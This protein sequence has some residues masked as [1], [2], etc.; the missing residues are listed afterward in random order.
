VLDVAPEG[1]MHQFWDAISVVSGIAIP[2]VVGIIVLSL[3]FR[4]TRRLAGEGTDLERFSI[5]GVLGN[6]FASVQMDDGQ[7]FERVRLVGFVSPGR[8]RLPYEFNSLVILEDEQGQRYFVRA[9]DIKT[10]VVP[11]EPRP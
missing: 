9:K 1:E 2:F 10:I 4:A 7:A 11:P 5:G 8:T 6:T 3:F